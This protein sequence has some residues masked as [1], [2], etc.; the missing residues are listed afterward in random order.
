MVD[1]KAIRPLHAWDPEQLGDLLLLG[2]IGQGGQGVVYLGIDKRGAQVAV[3]VL[4]EHTV[5]DPRH[6]TRFAREVAAAGK[7]ASFC[8][9][10]LL[11]A[12]LEGPTPYIVSEYVNG[13]TLQKLV[14]VNG[15]LTGD[16]LYR[17]ALGVA[18]ALTVIH[19][20]GIVHRDL[21]PDNVVL[22]PDGPRVIDFGLAR[23]MDTVVSTA[24]SVV[25]TPSYMAPERFQGDQPSPAGDVFAWAGVVLFAATGIPPFGTGEL[26]NVLHRI[27]Y[28]DP[29]LEPLV[30][31]LRSFVAAAIGK[32][33][34]LRPTAQDLLLG[35]LGG[36]SSD[37]L[38]D[39]QRIAG[40]LHPPPELVPELDTLSSPAWGRRKRKRL[41][42][43]G[44]ALSLTAAA[45]GVYSVALFSGSDG[46]V[47]PK[48]LTPAP[49]VAPP[50][51]QA[52][53]PGTWRGVVENVAG[54]SRPYTATFS[55]GAKTLTLQSRWLGE[56][57]KCVYLMKK[58][59]GV[60]RYVQGRCTGRGP[61]TVWRNEIGISRS[62]TSG[63]L[64]LS[65]FNLDN[66][67]KDTT[68]EFQPAAE[69]TSAAIPAVFHGSW[70]ESLGRD[71]IA[72]TIGPGPVA[73]LS[74]GRSCRWPL[75][76]WA[77]NPAFTVFTTNGS[78]TLLGT[79]H[80]GPV[81][82]VIQPRKG[83]S[84]ATNRLQFHFSAIGLD[85]SLAVRSGLKN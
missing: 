48:T 62:S 61:V 20:A 9:A 80:K 60:L 17:L 70:S 12:D 63:R 16:D 82:I 38:R 13:P 18:T 44:L 53:L 72:I 59:G 42:T 27:L 52:T 76:R 8:T 43:A 55:K 2:K 45:G 64:T 65:L 28:D 3:K 79:K 71:R 29:D 11:H 37:V 84:A 7:V 30:E 66:F 85:L 41:V 50:D 78:C 5:D 4:Y 24:S 57:A 56:K 36:H 67:G 26:A 39:G 54:V 23:S 83:I 46:T 31:P 10:K 77:A 25:G 68:G 49:S 73:D 6:R 74:D 1:L 40:D 81:A 69:A 15:P 33:P 51:L 35:L 75:T 19:Q 21:K 58:P 22:G 14:S 32:N 34:D 47:P